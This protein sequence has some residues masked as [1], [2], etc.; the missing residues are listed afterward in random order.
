MLSPTIEQDVVIDIIGDCGTPDGRK[1]VCPRFHHYCSR[2]SIP[3][4]MT[5]VKM[6]EQKEQKNPDLCFPPLKNHHNP[7]FHTRLLSTAQI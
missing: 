2:E 5:M 1:H 7:N 6:K 4:Q 3:L